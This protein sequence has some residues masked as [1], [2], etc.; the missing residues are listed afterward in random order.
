MLVVH[1]FAGV[2]FHVNSGDADFRLLS[3]NIQQDMAMLRQRIC[4]LGYLITFGQI[5]IK[6]ILPGKFAGFIDF[7]VCR[8]RHFHG[9]LDDFFI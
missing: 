3:V 2:F 7:A 8:Q 4:V 1:Q 9:E 5:R 6:I